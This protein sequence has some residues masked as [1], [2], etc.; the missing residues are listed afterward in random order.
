VRLDRLSE[1]EPR[2]PDAP[3]LMPP[4][5]AALPLAEPE[6]L[7][8]TTAAAAARAR[9]GVSKEWIFIWLGAGRRQKIER[10]GGFGCLGGSNFHVGLAPG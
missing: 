10:R 4:R 6:A 2:E 1:S 7:Q 5:P 9:R 8:E 3:A